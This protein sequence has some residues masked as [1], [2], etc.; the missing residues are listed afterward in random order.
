MLFRSDRTSLLP[1]AVRPGLIDVEFATPDGTR[2]TVGS[3]LL[4]SDADGLIVLH[5]GTVLL[6]HYAGV[7]TPTANHLLFSV[8]KSVT[9]LLTGLVVDRCG[10][11]PDA[12]VG[13]VVPEVAAGGFGDATVRDLLDMRVSIDFDEIYDDT[14]APMARYRES[15]GWL[16]PRDPAHPEDLRHFLASMDRRDG[17][18]GGAF[19]YLSPIIDM[20]GWVCETAAGRP[21]GEL[22]GE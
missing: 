8:T 10:L 11:D 9:G 6:E 2:R 16:P 18:H 19:R 15:T 20:L 21:Y 1:V 12:R 7:L 14:Y 17:A 4:E 22:V 13:S 5:R 3:W